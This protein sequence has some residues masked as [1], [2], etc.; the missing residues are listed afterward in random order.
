MAGKR[1]G[2][3]GSGHI[4]GWVLG[5]ETMVIAHGLYIL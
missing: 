3:V 4:V 1:L 5:T 2:L